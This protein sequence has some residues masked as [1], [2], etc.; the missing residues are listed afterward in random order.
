M[1]GVEDGSFQKGIAKETILAAVLLK[2]IEIEGAKIARITVDGL[3]ATE[4]AVK[5]LSEWNFGAVML[6]GVSFAG[7]NLIDPT[8]VYERFQKPVIVVSRKKPDNKAVKRALQKHF[9]DWEAR[10]QIFEKLGTA[11]RVTVRVDELPIYIE[12]VGTDFRTAQNLVRALAISSRI[13]EPLR[14]AKIVARGLS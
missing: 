14:A 13:P 2:G 8:V 10:W 11:L 3:D 12:T 6:A 4:K 1:V 9:I 5:I 7:F